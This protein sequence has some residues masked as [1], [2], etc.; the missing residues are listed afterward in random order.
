MLNQSYFHSLSPSLLCTALL[1]KA[2]VPLFPERASALLPPVPVKRNT[3]TGTLSL[4]V[5]K[6]SKSWDGVF[7]IVRAVTLL[8]VV[9]SDINTEC[10]MHV[11]P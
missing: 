5:D 1:S 6:K 3:S 8:P 4:L 7:E 9:S 11:L 2:P 10:L